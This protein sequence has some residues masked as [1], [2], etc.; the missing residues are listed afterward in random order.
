MT[1]QTYQ[2]GDDQ[3]APEND[4]IVR[5]DDQIV[6]ENDQIVPDDSPTMPADEHVVRADDQVMPAD[7][8]AVAEASAPD[9]G[10]AWVAADP[11]APATAAY[12]YPGFAPVVGV[13]PVIEI[14]EEPGAAGAGADSPPAGSAAAQETQSVRESPAASD[15]P[16]AGGRWREIQAMFVDDPRASVELAAGL[17]DDRVEA[18]VTSVRIGLAWR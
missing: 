7:E 5:E 17:V 3:M 8:Q 2:A 1:A 9:P 14:A 15:S 18:L 4:L 13:A 10:V 12:E 6:P 11:G 16:G